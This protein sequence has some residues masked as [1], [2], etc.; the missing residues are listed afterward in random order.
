MLK[1][2]LKLEEF[3]HRDRNSRKSVGA[4]IDANVSD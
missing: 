3:L 1:L 4:N 2:K